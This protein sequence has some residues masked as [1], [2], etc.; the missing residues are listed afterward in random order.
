MNWWTI[1]GGAMALFCAAGHAVAGWRMFY[2]PMRSAIGD[3]LHAGV[4][5]GMWHLIT[6]HFTL[7][8]MA[9][10]LLGYRGAGGAVAWLVAA[11]FAGYAAA[12]LVISLRLGGA[13]K[14]FQWIPFGSTAALAALGAATTP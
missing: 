14:L 9:L 11:Q 7:S 8:A 4:L 6:L 10:L 3:A 5:A 2:R 1:G 13:T 12:Y